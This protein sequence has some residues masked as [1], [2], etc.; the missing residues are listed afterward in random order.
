MRSVIDLDENGD[1]VFSIPEEL[2]WQEGDVVNLE[3]KDGAIVISRTSFVEV[4]REELE[5]LRE[6]EKLVRFIC[7]DTP[8]LSSEKQKW[9]LYDWYKRARKIRYP[10]SL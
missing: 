6:C 1:L 7:T 3:A 4:E 10:D 9:Q 5:F 2:G 8:E